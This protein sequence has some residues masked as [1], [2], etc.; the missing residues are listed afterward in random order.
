MDRREIGAALALRRVRGV[1][2]RGF[3][4]LIDQMGSAQ[5]VLGACPEELQTRAGVSEAL[6]R[7]LAGRSPGPEDGRQVAQAAAR[8]V[9]LVPYGAADYPSLLAEIADPP[10]V[11]YV[12]GELD[13]Q[14][15]PAVAVVGSRRASVHGKRFA[16][17]LARDLAGHGVTV[18]SG[19]A[20]GIDAAAHR[21]ALAGGGRTVAVFGA[22]LDVVYPSSNEGLA[23]E[24]RAQ[25]AW[26]SELPLG[27]EPRAHHF[28]RRNRIISGLSLGV[29]VVEAAERSGS[30]ITA[31][32]A[33]DQGREVFAVPGLPGAMTAAGTHN[34]LRAGAKLVER[35]EDVLE[36]L[37]PWGTLLPQKGG[38]C[39]PAE[40]PR[41]LRA[42]WDA[43]EETPLSID[44]VAGRA[45]VGPGE[46]AAGLMEL[47]L[48]GYVYEWPGKR[49]ARCRFG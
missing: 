39:P 8:G 38:G 47:V 45:G 10:A 36:E 17:R 20:G 29:V 14:G 21:G 1:G 9:A 12:A 27:S 24:I 23:R 26:V 4:R 3:K 5:A 15:T 13:P 37:P 22:G 7:V 31:R 25:G 34:L 11:L 19:L 44:E 18:V 32:C 42:L 2:D 28:P 30:L 35:A 41:G 46:A 40:P 49:Y 16:Q 43:L 48:G 33:L 6:A